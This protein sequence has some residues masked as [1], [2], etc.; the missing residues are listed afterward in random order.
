M[1]GKIKYR[2]VPCQGTA[3]NWPYEGFHICLNQPLHLMTR[4]EDGRSY[5]AANAAVAKKAVATPKK[6]S[7]RVPRDLKAGDPKRIER[8]SKIVRLYASN[9]LTMREIAIEMDLDQTTVMNVLHNAADRG[10]VII[11]RAVRRSVGV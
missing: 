2:D 4:V 11:R 3:C 9:N 7:T 5:R 8:N 10:D 6:K 1:A